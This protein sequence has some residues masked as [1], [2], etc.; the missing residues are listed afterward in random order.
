LLLAVIHGFGQDGWRD[1]QATQTYLLKNAAGAN[2]EA[3]SAK[4]SQA[5]NK[6]QPNVR[7]DVLA[8]VLDGNAGYLYFSN[9]SYSWY[10]PKTFTGEPEKRR[11]HGDKMAAR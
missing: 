4:D 8:Q 6:K 7:G 11:G 9:F 2:L 1:S 5:N 3:R 10:D